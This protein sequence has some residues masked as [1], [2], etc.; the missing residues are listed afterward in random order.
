MSFWARI[1]QAARAFMA[2]RN[3][4]DQLSTGMLWVGLALYL[5]GS[6][7]SIEVL[8]LLG[9]AVY[10]VVIFRIF[11]R[12]KEKRNAENRRY[13]NAKQDAAKKWKQA[14]TRQANRK[15]YK[16]FKCPGCKAWLKLPRGAG[17]V[18]VTCSRCQN[19]FTEKA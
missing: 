19:H 2:G 17:V 12:N 6:I 4:T 10:C 7:F 18:T 5:L 1:K 15:Q 9:F 8:P 16:Y 11:S 3:G 14:K 13:L